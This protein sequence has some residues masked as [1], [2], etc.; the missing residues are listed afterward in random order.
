MK[1]F[2]TSLLLHDFQFI[3]L[4]NIKHEKQSILQD[5]ILKILLG[6]NLITI[7]VSNLT[8][9]TQNIIKEKSNGNRIDLSSNYTQTSMRKTREYLSPSLRFT[10]W[11]SEI[12]VKDNQLCEL[13]KLMNC[14]NACLRLHNHSFVFLQ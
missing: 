6:L 12:E 1:P 8:K 11:K 2:Q 5:L 7:L 13:I 14:L 9:H 10:K 3:V 4:A